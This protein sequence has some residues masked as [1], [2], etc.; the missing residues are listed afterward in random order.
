MKTA[1][2]LLN[3][4]FL[5]TGYIAD[6]HAKAL[7]S[8]PNASLTAVCDRDVARARAFAAR[9]RVARIHPS[10]EAMLAGGQLMLSMSCSLPISTRHLPAKSSTP[11][12]TSCWKNRWL[13]VSR[14]VRN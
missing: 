13:P 4:G 2:Q 9:H 8:V 3:V 6:W 7:R 14:P 10:L 12:S 5:G 11:A 1:N